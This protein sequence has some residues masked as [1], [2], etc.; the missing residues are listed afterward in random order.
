LTPDEAQGQKDAGLK[1]DVGYQSVTG[2]VTGFRVVKEAV[3]VT[4]NDKDYPV[5]NIKQIIP[6]RNDSKQLA[7]I[8]NAVIGRDVFWN[9]D[10][11]KAVFGAATDV[12]FSTDGSV[13]VTVG[14]QTVP[15]SQITRIGAA[16]R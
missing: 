6:E 7:E 10:T 4:V 9:D 14:D 2:R 5:D 13:R 8:A 1:P 12:S 15:F 3:Y 11:G 16:G